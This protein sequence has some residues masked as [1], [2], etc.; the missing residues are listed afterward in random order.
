MGGGV[1]RTLVVTVELNLIR[2]LSVGR[3]TIWLVFKDLMSTVLSAL[4]E[5]ILIFII[6]LGR[7]ARDLRIARIVGS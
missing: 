1:T 2:R 6:A 7:C 3:A 4:V 5:V